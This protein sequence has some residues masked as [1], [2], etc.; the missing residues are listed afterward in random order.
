MEFKILNKLLGYRPYE[1]KQDE[2]VPL[3]LEAVREAA[4]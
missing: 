4:L 2:K 3:F 1:L